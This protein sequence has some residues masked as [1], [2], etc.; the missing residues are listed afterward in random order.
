[1]EGVRRERGYHMLIC[2]DKLRHQHVI[3]APMQLLLMFYLI[4]TEI[5]NQ[6]RLKVVK[7]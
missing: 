7:E 3:Y 6:Y 2:N 5:I 4:Y 1:M